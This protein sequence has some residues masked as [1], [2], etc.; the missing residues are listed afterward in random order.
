M[1]EY[2]L[3]GKRLDYSF[4]KAFFT[5]Y[6]EQ[7]GIRA[8]YHN[9]EIAAIE[10]VRAILSSGKYSGLNVT[11]PYKETV[12]P[13]LD[14]LSPEAKA[15]GAVNTISFKNG[16]T[17]GHNTDAFGF[18]QSIKPFL[19]NKHERALVLGTGGASKA[20]SYVL[21]DIG[22]NVLHVSR[23]PKEENT[24]GYEEINGHMLNACKMIVNCTPVGTFPDV[25]D[26]PDLPTEFIGPDHF[27]VDLIYNPEKTRLLRE[28]EA[29]GAIIL[30]GHSMLK[31]QALKAWETW[32]S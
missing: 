32:N 21:E 20:V 13:Y 7:N 15:I 1:P 31:E 8:S 17:I 11:I 24:F 23:N 6:F 30:N 5:A 10:E 14:E 19:N 22:L 25:D 16:K 26:K 4:S 2:G 3:I 12:I 29:K 28:A 18:R 9:I 27:V